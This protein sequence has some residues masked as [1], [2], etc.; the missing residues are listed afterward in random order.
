MLFRSAVD[1]AFGVHTDQAPSDWS[2]WQPRVQ[3][4][5]QLGREAR[6]VLRVGAGLFT[7]QLPYYAQHNQLLYTGTSLADI[8]LRNAAVPAPNFPSYRADPSTVPGLSPG[9]V[10]PPP[11][12]NVVGTYSAPRSLKGE[13]A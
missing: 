9:A 4:V 11:Y 10:L 8:D 12:V 2:Q 7:A 1:A 13:L 6:S 3:L 5:W